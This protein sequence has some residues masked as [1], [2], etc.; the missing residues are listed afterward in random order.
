MHIHGP[1]LGRRKDAYP[2]LFEN[3]VLILERKAL[4]VSIIGLNFPFEI[5]FYEYV[6]EKTPTCSP[7][8]PLF[9]S[10][11]NKMFIEVP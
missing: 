5:S 1:Q 2:A 10:A 3:R 9:F 8:V 7:A 4:I 6:G 11:F